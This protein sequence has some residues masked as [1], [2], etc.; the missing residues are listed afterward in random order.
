MTT[1]EYKK[2]SA[3]RIL[4]ELKFVRDKLKEVET[5]GHRKKTDDHGVKAQLFN[6]AKTLWSKYGIYTRSTWPHR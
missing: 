2:L 5:V 4:E 1:D 3:L 6:S